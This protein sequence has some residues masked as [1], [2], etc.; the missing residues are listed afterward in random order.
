MPEEKVKH[1]LGSVR[2]D[3]EPVLGMKFEQSRDKLL[4]F[5]SSRDNPYLK[6]S[7]I[8]QVEN[9]EGKDAG[10]DLRKEINFKYDEEKKIKS[11][12]FIHNPNGKL[13][14][15]GIDLGQPRV[16]T[17]CN[18][19]GERCYIYM[20]IKDDFGNSISRCSSCGTD[21]IELNEEAFKLK[22]EERN[23]RKNS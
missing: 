4:H 18:E 1:K 5:K 12:D 22:Q 21:C 8:R 7:L 23:G 9:H 3:G 19:C 10:A 14:S 13:M 15:T 16:F 17:W 20:I 11:V 6:E 2:K